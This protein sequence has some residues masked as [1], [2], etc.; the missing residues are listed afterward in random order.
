MII[1]LKFKINNVNSLLNI[2]N[3]NILKQKYIKNEHIQGPFID[4][5]LIEN[6]N[7]TEFDDIIKKHFFVI[8]LR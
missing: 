5:K 4:L 8:D 7:K 1:I 2:K 3:N 6:I